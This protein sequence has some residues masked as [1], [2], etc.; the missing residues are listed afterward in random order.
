MAFI[1]FIFRF[2]GRRQTMLSQPQSQENLF[3]YII[4]TYICIYTYINLCWAQCISVHTCVCVCVYLTKPQITGL[5]NYFCFLLA[6]GPSSQNCDPVRIWSIRALWTV[7]KSVGKIKRNKT[8]CSWGKK[9]SC[10]ISSI[11]LVE[12]SIWF[13]WIWQNLR[14]IYTTSGIIYFIGIN[15]TEYL[16]YL[17]KLKKYSKLGKKYA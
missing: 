16:T 5:T 2:S 12:L 15:S 7:G 10:E 6:S 13:I 11:R 8:N 3:I 4:Y 17:W 1:F 14:F 9:K